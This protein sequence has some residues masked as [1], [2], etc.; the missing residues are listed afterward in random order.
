[1]LFLNSVSVHKS[2]TG[3]TS[4]TCS[5]QN[6]F[7]TLNFSARKVDGVNEPSEAH[8]SG[9]VLIVVEDWNVTHLFEFFLDVEAVGCFNILEID[10]TKRTGDALYAVDKLV[11]VLRVN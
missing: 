9:T 3:D 1:M 2:Q 10:A 7:S 5:I 11:R 8:N 6:D 4:C